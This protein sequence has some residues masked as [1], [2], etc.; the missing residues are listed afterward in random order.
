MVLEKLFFWFR[1]QKHELGCYV[2]HRCNGECCFFFI[3]F[4]GLLVLTHK[5]LQGSG[6]YQ[7]FAELDSKTEASSD[8]TAIAFDKGLGGKA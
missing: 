3:F 4:K 7:D 2:I 1:T 5:S 8:A 6:P